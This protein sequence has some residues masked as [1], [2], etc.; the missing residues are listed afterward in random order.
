M[1]MMGNPIEAAISGN[2]PMNQPQVIGSSPGGGGPGGG[3]G[4]GAPPPPLGG[5][6]N[7]AEAPTATQRATSVEPTIT[8]PDTLT[9]SIQN[10][11][12]HLILVQRGQEQVD[13]ESLTPQME[14]FL[15]LVK[16]LQ[17]E[18]E[19]MDESY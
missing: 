18:G 10:V 14:T 11:N 7:S 2:S 8:I 19:E 6:Y 5:G 12:K 4:I 15:Q 3:I 1:P 16:G 17:E 13:W 9:A